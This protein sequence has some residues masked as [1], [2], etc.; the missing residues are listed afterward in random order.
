MNRAYQRARQDLVEA[1]DALL[2]LMGI[3]NPTIPQH[4]GALLLAEG[5]LRF[6]HRRGI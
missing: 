2:A 6:I 5:L 3:E 1:H 4:T